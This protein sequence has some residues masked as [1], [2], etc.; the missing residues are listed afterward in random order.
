MNNTGMQEEML[1]DT[2]GW[3]DSTVQVLKKN[4]W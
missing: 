3:E 2:Q 1:K 4:T